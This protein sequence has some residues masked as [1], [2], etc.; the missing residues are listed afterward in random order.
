M[1]AQAPPGSAGPR[2]RQS[3]KEPRTSHRGIWRWLKATGIAAAGVAIL[4]G[5]TA[6]RA[7]SEPLG[8]MR[9]VPAAAL[10]TV[11]AGNPVHLPWPATGES[12]LVTTSGLSFGTSGPDRPLPIA[13][14]TKVMTAYLVLRDHP[15]SAGE[16]GPLIT[17]S[18]S[19]AAQLPQDEKEGQSLIPV[20]AGEQLSE[21]QALEA[22]LIPSAD[23]I[24]HVLA[25][26]DAGSDAAFVAK[27]NATAGLLGMRSTH[28]AGPSGYNPA[29]VSTPGDQLK[30]A[31]AA[32]A[33][34]AFAAIVAEPKV[35]LPYAGTVDNYNSL[36]GHN[37]YFGIKT[38]ST[39]QAGGCLVW[40]VTRR[41]A[42]K[43]VTILGAVFGQTGGPYVA[44]ALRAAQSLTNAAFAALRPRTVIPAGAVVFEI[45]RAGRQTLAVTTRSLKTIDPPGT[46]VAVKIRPPAGEIKD[47]KAQPLATLS[48]ASPDS[49]AS[50]PVQIVHPLQPPSL[51]WRLSH[52]L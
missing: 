37:G 26:F 4:V 13:S 20:Q 5:A 8:P 32:M 11:V 36:A 33:L 15:L 10:P 21:Q 27:M 3:P 30:L 44:A 19:Q 17:I 6:I 45:E 22:L 31:R 1:T 18:A 2:H 12:D 42:G 41:V 7:A 16:A 47:P 14:V 49:T 46:A 28:Y 35:S 9:A 38:G 24:A 23:N 52:L 48:L 43:P 25:D 34:P 50:S 51:R 39:N 40:A 29:S